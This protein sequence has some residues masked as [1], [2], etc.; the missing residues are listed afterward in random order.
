[1]GNTLRSYFN[2][3]SL[4]GATFIMLADLARYLISIHAPSRER[5]LSMRILRQTFAIS[6]HAPSRE[7]R[8]D[9]I[10]VGVVYFISIHA[11]SRERQTAKAIMLDN[12]TISI[13]APSR[14]RPYNYHCV[15]AVANFNP[16]SLAGATPLRRLPLP[17]LPKF[18]STLPRGSD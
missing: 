4:A 16:R 10:V 3:R 18:Q 6:I 2:P 8:L 11:P 12:V 14:E 1:M 15:P 5:P 7:R 13:H 17:A 9:S